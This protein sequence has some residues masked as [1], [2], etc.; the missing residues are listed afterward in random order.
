MRRTLLRLLVP[1]LVAGLAI[2]ATL[3]PAAADGPINW[4]QWGQNPQHQGFV[5]V[6]G[7]NL[8]K[9][10]ADLVYDPNV[11]AEMASTGGDL[12]AHYQAPLLHENDVFMEFKGGTFTDADHWNTQTWSERRYHCQETARARSRT[13]LVS[14]VG[15]RF[16]MLCSPTAPSMCPTP[17]APSRSWPWA[18]APWSRK[19]TPA[20]RRGPTPPPSWPGR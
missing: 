20:I 14:E 13:G 12:L 3:A 17:T 19:L 4:P 15:S 11:P 18:T 1:A 6:A 8:N 7:Q 5:D 10:L 2:T 9:I 16:S